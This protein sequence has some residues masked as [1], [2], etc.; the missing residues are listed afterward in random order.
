MK[1]FPYAEILCR[2][3]ACALIQSLHRENRCDSCW[4]GTEGPRIVAP[5]LRTA[6]LIKLNTF[7]GPVIR[8]SE[9]PKGSISWAV[10][11]QKKKKKEKETKYQHE[12]GNIS[13]C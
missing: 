2:S 4:I 10:K 7:H 5:E 6:V 11:C 8:V 12:T 3:M 1:P 9:C 13:F